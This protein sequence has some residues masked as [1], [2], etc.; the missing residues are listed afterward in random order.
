[1]RCNIGDRVG[2]IMK[3][4]DKMVWFYG[5]GVYEGDTI[6]PEDV[7]GMNFGIPNP[8]I[9][10]DNGN[11]VYGCECWCGSESAVKDMIGTR[12][13]ITVEPDRHRDGR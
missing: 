5:Y 11:I 8:T 12:E 1:M 3:A 6:P 9:K 13:I 10:L 4:D 2:A 7:G